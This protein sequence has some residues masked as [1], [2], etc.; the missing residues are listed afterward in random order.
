MNNIVFRINHADAE[1]PNEEKYAKYIEERKFYSSNQGYD[2]VGYVQSGAK[3][4]PVLD[5]VKYVENNEKSKG[6][7]GPNGLYSPEEIKSLRKALSS[8]KSPIWHGFISLEEAFGKK[9]CN[10]YEQALEFFNKQ[11]PRFLSQA[12]FD[13]SNIT[14]FAGL[15]ENTNHRHIHFL[16]FENNPTRYISKDKELHYS[17]GK[18]NKKFIEKAKIDFE[19]SFLTNINAIKDL[20]NEIVNTTKTV[21][22]K[23]TTFYPKLARKL[24]L[25]SQK[26]PK[27]GRLGYDSENMQ[28]L[29]KDVDGISDY[30]IKKRRGLTILNLEYES[31]V[32]AK[33]IEI[34]RICKENKMKPNKYLL[35]D[36]YKSDLYRR[37]GNI[38]IQSAVKE[39]YQSLEKTRNL[40]S[41]RYEKMQ[42]TRNLKYWIERSIY[43]YELYAYEVTKAFEDYEEA[44]RKN[45]RQIRAEMSNF[46]M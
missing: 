13:N 27:D 6:I 2:F 31:K 37:L 8:T 24:E 43:L 35:L 23:D 33:D 42:R 17:V 18:I 41:H 25:L 7:F 12:G 34:A 21:F 29:K 14:Y 32:I 5:F 1:Y 22:E 3:N 20:R 10:T 38:V 11:F 40:A 36:K 30:V 9:Y 4:K 19:L 46:D 16:F 39:N 45:E 44:L 15:H 26:L 28:F